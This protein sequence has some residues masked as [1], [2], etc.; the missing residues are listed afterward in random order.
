MLIES[1]FDYL[2][3]LD[4]TASWVPM[5]T[6]PGAQGAEVVPPV[7]HDVLRASHALENRRFAAE[8][9]KDIDYTAL[10]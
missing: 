3:D 5:L 8:V 10:G 4:C 6:E 1:N 9:L 2:L 7:R